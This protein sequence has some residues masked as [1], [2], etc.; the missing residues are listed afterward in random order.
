MR[1]SKVVAGDADAAMGER[2]RRQRP[3]FAHESQHGKVARAAA[4]IGD[5]DGFLAIQFARVP[6]GGA[7]RFE[8]EFDVVPASNFKCRPQ[9]RDGERV[10]RLIPREDDG[11]SRHHRHR[12]RSSGQ[13]LVVEE[14]G[15]KNRDEAFDCEALAIKPRLGEEAARKVRLDGLDEALLA[16]LRDGAGDCFRSG[17]VGDF[18]PL[19]PEHQSRAKR[20]RRADAE[21]QRRLSTWPPAKASATTLFVVPKSTPIPVRGRNLRRTSIFLRL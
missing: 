16:F 6:I 7:E 13:V 10:I 4:E 11:A 19:A 9:A 12:L 3:I 20:V 18:A 8:G 15:Q 17:G 21:G 5:E 14:S 1:K 2:A